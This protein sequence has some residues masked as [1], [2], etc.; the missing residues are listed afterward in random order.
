M[1]VVQNAEQLS[2]L[3]LSVLFVSSPGSQLRASSLY[4]LPMEWL[5][6]HLPGTVRALLSVVRALPKHAARERK[7]ISSSLR[8]I[9][10]RAVNQTAGKGP[11]SEPS[12]LPLQ[13][14]GVCLS[15]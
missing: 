7:E 12:A 15:C 4:R 14:A 6:Q 9:V 11:V 3:W 10:G 2:L 1:A 8:S 13:T 5:R